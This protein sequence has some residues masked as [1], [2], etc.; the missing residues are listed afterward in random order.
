MFAGLLGQDRVAR[1]PLLDGR[2][3]QCLR[4][5]VRLGDHIAGT[6][7]V[8]LLQAL[9]AVHQHGSGTSCEIE[10][11]VEVGGQRGSGCRLGQ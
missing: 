8:D 10:T 1:K 4:L 6:L 2:D 7:V 9:V 3:D 11:E 5:M